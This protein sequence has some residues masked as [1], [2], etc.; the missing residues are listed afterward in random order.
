MAFVTT[1]P[2]GLR[3]EPTTAKRI[4]QQTEP[5]ASEHRVMTAHWM[6]LGIKRL[7]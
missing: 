2:G 1:P 3:W 4:G 5:I 7:V 6:T